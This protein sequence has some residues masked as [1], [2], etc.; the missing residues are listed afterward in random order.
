MLSRKQLIILCC[1]FLLVIGGIVAI[2]IARQSAVQQQPLTNSDD[3]PSEALTVTKKYFNLREAAVDA[4]YST[5]HDWANDAKPIVT[6][7]MYASISKDNPAIAADYTIARAAHF[8][9][10]TTIN[11]CTW[12]VETGSHTNTG[13]PIVCTLR[14]T[15]LDQTTK[16]VVPYESIPAGWAHTGRRI[17]EAAI[18]KQNGKWLVDKDLSSSSDNQPAP[19]AR[20]NINFQGTNNLLNLGVS[21]PQVTALEQALF[22]F[23]P[24]VEG[25]RINSSNISTVSRDDSSGDFLLSFNVTF[26]DHFTY[27]ATIDYYGLYNLQLRL[28]NSHGEIV[29]NSGDINGSTL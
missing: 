22:A 20:T 9:V 24:N 16:A 27:R 2:F 7:S 15:T 13:G 1:F 10:E 6:S 28:V 11:N 8:V 18:V 19:P 5:S 4:T 23:A 3:L 14:D 25:V 17:A 26:D 29:Y 12:N 21:D